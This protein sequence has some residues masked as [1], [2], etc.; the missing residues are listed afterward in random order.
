MGVHAPNYDVQINGGSANA[1]LRR[2]IQSVEFESVDGMADLL[3]INAV[4]PIDDNGN[5]PIRDSRIFQPGNEISVFAGYGVRVRHV[6]RAVVRKLRPIFP[7]SG[8]PTVEVI[9]YSKDA[10]MADNSPEPL[11]ERKKPLKSA[12]AQAR[13]EAEGKGFKDSKAGRRFTDTT[14]AVAIIE[15]A[16]NY[17]FDPD[18]DPTLDPPHDFIQKAGM[19]DYDFVRGLSNLTG[20][21]F[22]VDA[23]PDGKWTLHFKNPDTIDAEAFQ[24]KQFTFKYNEGDFSTLL[25]FEPELAIQGATTKLVVASKDVLTGRLLQVN[26]QE[27][28]DQGPEVKADSPQGDGNP[29]QKLFQ[30]PQIS[31]KANKLDKELTTGTEIKLFLGDFSFDIKSNRTFRN[32]AELAAWG[33]SWFRR[34][35][36]NF[37]LARATLIGVESL[38][39]RQTHRLSGIGTGLSGEYFFTRVRH[40]INASGYVIDANCRKIVSQ[41]PSAVPQLS[42]PVNPTPN[43][44]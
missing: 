44:P 12:K 25:G 30:P 27:E 35:R 23:T 38:N 21:Y 39:A 6:G 11:K 37:V 28:N 41:L 2:L 9:G 36:E 22:W 19:S 14:Y 31:I 33:Q 1:A 4:D 24:E 5:M 8:V 17:G 42:A 16:A 40:I 7:Q 32:E 10:T 34:N 26:L 3:R 43:S 18:V 20:F 29:F 13:R 15:R